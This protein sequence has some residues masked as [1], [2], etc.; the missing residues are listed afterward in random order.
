[1]S[2][3]K[4]NRWD[5]TKCGVNQGANDMWHESDV[6]GE[7]LDLNESPEDTEKKY[8]VTVILINMFDSLGM[9]TPSNFDEINQFCFEDICETA[10]SENWNDS[11]VSIA[12]RRWIEKQVK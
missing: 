5:C 10:D 7:C 9:Q 1:M 4:N 2:S 8:E 11:D 3:I 6:C 12:F